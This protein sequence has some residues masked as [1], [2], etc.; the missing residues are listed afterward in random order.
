MMLNFRKSWWSVVGMI[1]LG[2]TLGLWVLPQIFH[3]QTAP[4]LTVNDSLWAELASEAAPSEVAEFKSGSFL[5]SLN[6]S[7][8]QIQQLRSLRAQ[9]QPQIREQTRNFRATKAEFRQLLASDATNSEIKA[10][11]DEVQKQRQALDQLRLESITS[12]RDILTAEQRQA[13]AQQRQERL[14]QRNQDGPNRRSR[15]RQGRF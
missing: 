15:R 5:R 8:T 3:Q 13:F 6:L 4:S 14:D 9:Y 11:F 12:L 7:S 1:A 2:T 10:Q